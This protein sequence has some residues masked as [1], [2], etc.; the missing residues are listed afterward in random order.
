MA[1]TIIISGSLQGLGS[2]WLNHYEDSG[3]SKEAARL[4]VSTYGL[5]AIGGRII[6]GLISERVHIRHVFLFACVVT[7]LPLLLLV[8]VSTL[9]AAMLYSAAAGLT[10]GGYVS[11]QALIWADYF[12]RRNLGAIRA[13]FATPSLYAAAAGPWWIAF[14]HDNLGGYDWAYW[15]MLI[16]WLSAAALVYLARP[17][18]KKT[19]ADQAPAAAG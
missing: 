10:L 3:L 1:A 15:I 14:V 16:G 6:W 17:L 5:F 19:P 13:Y 12:G 7:G 18:R 2:S 8:N 11:V 4:A 9:P